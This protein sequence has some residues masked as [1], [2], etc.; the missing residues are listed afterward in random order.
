MMN[1]TLCC[2][3][4]K[5]IFKPIC[6]LCDV[7]VAAAAAVVVNLSSPWVSPPAAAANPICQK[8]ARVKVFGSAAAA[9]ER[10][11]LFLARKP[12]V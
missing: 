2:A 12:P 7:V 1:N 9:A 5:G 11:A 6:R 3:S 8:F 10:T 4:G